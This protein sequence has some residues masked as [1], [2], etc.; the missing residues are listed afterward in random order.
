MQVDLSVYPIFVSHP[1]IIEKEQSI[2]NCIAKIA[3]DLRL[4]VSWPF[5]DV[6]LPFVSNI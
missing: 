3:T 4:A 2:A 1:C 6:I 5:L